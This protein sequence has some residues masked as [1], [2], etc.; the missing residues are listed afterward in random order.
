MPAIR[1]QGENSVPAGVLFD[2]QTAKL[3]A[4]KHS[5]NIPKTLCV[6]L[7]GKNVFQWERLARGMKT[8]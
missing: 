2:L 6:L 1:I 4:A 5:E 8:V 3:W 7:V